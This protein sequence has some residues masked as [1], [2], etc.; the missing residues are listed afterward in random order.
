MKIASLL[1]TLT[2]AKPLPAIRKNEQNE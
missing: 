2:I 1:P